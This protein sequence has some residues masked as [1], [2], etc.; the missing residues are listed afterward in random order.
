MEVQVGSWDT[1]LNLRRCL[2][3]DT[4]LGIISIQ[5]VFKIRALDEITQVE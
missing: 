5:V 1:Y 3:T 4:N 2:T